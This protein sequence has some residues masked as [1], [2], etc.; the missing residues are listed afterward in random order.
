[1]KK[2]LVLALIST[3]LLGFF[4]FYTSSGIKPA[5]WSE[6]KTE[7][8]SDTM[9]FTL[10]KGDILVHPN[11]GWFPGSFSVPNGWRYGHVAI[12]TEEASG[13]T[14]DEAL[15]KASV[16]EALFFDQATRKFLF[17][18]KDQ[19]REGKAIVSFGNRFKGIRYRLR[20]NLSDDQANE[21]VRFLRNQ[22]EGG[23]NIFSL[24]KQFSSLV[25]KENAIQNLK[26]ANWQCATLSWEV[27]Y[28][29]PRVDID[30][31]GGLIVYPSD[32]IASSCFDVPGGRIRF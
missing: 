19:I 12:V 25:E 32:I 13:N 14:V 31:N 15:S 27:Y 9:A 5:D 3:F 23:Y 7:T 17:R 24:K 28:L 8:L 11:W 22:L 6:T 20:M 16:V 21:M 1:M 29:V 18:K 26:N 2:K 10:K 4:Y 30:A